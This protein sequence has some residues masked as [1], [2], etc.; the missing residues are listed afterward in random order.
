MRSLPFFFPK[1]C[2]IYQTQM[3]QIY[4]GKNILKKTSQSSLENLE[5]SFESRGLQFAMTKTPIVSIV[6]LK[7]QFSMG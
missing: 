4:S 5:S 6:C 7:K 1:I 3:L 2:D